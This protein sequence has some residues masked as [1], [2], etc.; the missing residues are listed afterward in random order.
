[1][2][3][4][5]EVA[6]PAGV[7]PVIAS[8]ATFG[9]RRATW[10]PS[11]LSFADSVPPSRASRR[12]RISACD[13]SKPATRTTSKAMTTPSRTISAV[14][15]EFPPDDRDVAGSAELERGRGAAGA[16]AVAQVPGA[17]VEPAGTVQAIAVPVA[18]D[19]DP[20]GTEL[21]VD[22]RTAVGG[23]KDPRGAANDTGAGSAVVRPPAHH[24]DITRLTELELDVGGTG[25]VRVAQQP[26]V[27]AHNAGSGHPVAIPVAD[28]G[29][30]TS[31]TEFEGQFRLAGSFHLTDVPREGLVSG[32]APSGA[33]DDRR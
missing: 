29:D 8:G 6:E 10:S 4:A 16:Q 25:G 33:A 3:V 14:I 32:R 9:A 24:R 27:A 21:E 2:R 23:A 20:A 30:V 11:A 1:F 15:S 31:L 12:R 17:V 13:R 18:D 5:M 19:R 22:G 26:A 28:D 7:V